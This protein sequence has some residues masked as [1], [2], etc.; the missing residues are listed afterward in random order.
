MTRGGDE[1][2]GETISVDMWDVDRTEKDPVGQS[3][4]TMTGFTP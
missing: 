1:G 2:K 4:W 3:V